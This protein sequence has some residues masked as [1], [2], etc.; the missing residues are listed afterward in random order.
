MK[1]VVMSEGSAYLSMTTAGVWLAILAIWLSVLQSLSGVA[2]GEC[3]VTGEDGGDD[4]W[5]IDGGQWWRTGHAA[6]VLA[7]VWF[8][9][10]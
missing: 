7:R 6:E 10:A 1:A 2:N 5:A 3:V 9:A 8:L 4:E